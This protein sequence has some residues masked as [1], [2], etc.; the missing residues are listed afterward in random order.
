MNDL[1]SVLHGLE[2]FVLVYFAVLTLYYAS[3]AFLGLRMIV[4]SSRELSPV[5]LKDLLDHQYYKPVS[6]LVPAYNEE[7]AIVGLVDSLLATRYPQFEVI[8]GVDGATD[9]TLERLVE[10]YDLQET[11]E[12]YRRSVETRPVH[13]IL[14]SPHHPQLG[15]V[16]KDNGGRADAI[17]AALNLARYP[18]VCV[19]DADSLLNPE[20]LARASRLFIE[21]DSVIAAGGSLR[22]L[23][24][25]LVRDA[26]VI[27]AGTPRRWVERIQVLEYARS[28][29]IA[30]AAWSRLGSLMIIS[31]AFGIF[32]RE[33]VIEVGGWT[34]GLVADDMEMVVKL[35][36]HFR[37]MRQR[38]R[39]A[40]TPDPL[41]WTEVPDRIRDLRA[42]RSMWE[43]GVL[44]VLW[45]HRRMLFNPRYGRIGMVGIPYLWLFETGATVV[46]TMGYLLVVVS[47][48]AGVLDVRFALLFFT[49]AVLFGALFSELGM[50]IQALL[51]VRHRRGR[52]RLALFLAAFAEY[53]GIR[54]LVL[55][56]R[57]VA[58]FQVRRLRGR[59]WQ[60]STRAVPR[61][62]GVQHAPR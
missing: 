11:P 30:R 1:A 49:L 31:G 33:A 29:F 21:D 34:P 28:F 50:T 4:A 51:L 18:L 40:F 26:T 59:Y 32:R 52:D 48:L 38:Y 39:V 15:V 2:A 36:R 17:N 24:G 41:C 58:L 44:E 7:D 25:A 56:S 60:R 62:P 42:Q 19:I 53:I 46:E 45:R 55:L 9:R 54:Q 10:R 13:R 47:L 22:P 23:N 27:D 8:V 6:I 5:A 37:D 12:V 57:T 61:G 16:E 43:R 35:H 3:A 14:R 20:A